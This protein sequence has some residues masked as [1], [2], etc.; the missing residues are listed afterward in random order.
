MVAFKGRRPMG[1]GGGGGRPFGGGGSGGG[2]SR[3]FG[4]GSGKPFGGGGKFGKKPKFRK[5]FKKKLKRKPEVAAPAMDQTGLEALY[6][7]TL[8]EEETPI[9]VV[10][11]SGEKIKGLVKYYDKDTFSFGPSD[12]SPKLFVR[13]DGVKYLYEE[14][15]EEVAEAEAEEVEDDEEIEEDEALVA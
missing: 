1:G 14:P 5:P 7:K 15:L 9:V 13:K 12:G 3:P 2:G 11:T 10:L 4:G 6:L 8:M